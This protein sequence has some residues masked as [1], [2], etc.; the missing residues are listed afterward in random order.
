MIKLI[1]VLIVSCIS[2]SDACRFIRKPDEQIYCESGFA[3][4]ITVA[5]TGYPCGLY[6]NNLCYGINNVEQINGPSI[7]PLIL[8]TGLDSAGCGVTLDVGSKYFIASGVIN[9]S[10]VSLY[11]YGL[12]EDWTA[13]SPTDVATATLAY[14]A[15]VCPVVITTPIKTPIKT[16]PTIGPIKTL[17]TTGPIRTLPVERAS[18]A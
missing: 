15:T 8:Q 2:L 13:L 17:P 3:G 6:N 14:Q 10:V 16:L 11:T 1:M 7:T 12:Y 4:I 5:S 18:L 9:T